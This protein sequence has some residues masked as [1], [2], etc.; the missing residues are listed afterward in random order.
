MV[1]TIIFAIFPL[2]S[3]AGM[4]FI[5]GSIWF[6]I[7][8]TNWPRASAI[9]TQSRIALALPGSNEETP[10][11]HYEYVANKIKYSSSRIAMYIVNSLPREESRKI[12]NDFKL[13][14]EVIIR[15]HPLI[16]N[17]SVLEPGV[18]Q[19]SVHIFLFFLSL[20][21]FLLSMAAIL[22]PDS[23]VIFDAIMWFSK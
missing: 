17:I 18:K 21:L 3:L 1:V 16:K 2:A 14:K 19:V 9:I 6:G 22:V 5:A 10:V 13:G 23:I 7:S 11:I 20:L 15:Y 12:L 8:N 4:V